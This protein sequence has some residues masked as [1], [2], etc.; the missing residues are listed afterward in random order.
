MGA[1]D[2][3]VKPYSPGELIARIH[4]VLRRL[5]PALAGEK[6]D[7]AGIVLDLVARRVTRDGAALRLTPIEFR[8]LQALVERPGRVRHCHSN[9]SDFDRH[10]GVA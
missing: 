10:I 5:R 2:Y 1:N 7:L 9:R 4:A 6:L 3:M 8:I